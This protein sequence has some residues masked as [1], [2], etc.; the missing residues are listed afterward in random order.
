MFSN[1][2]PGSVVRLDKI[3]TKVSKLSNTVTEKNTLCNLD[4]KK[5]ARWIIINIL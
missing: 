1:N 3:T 2:T 5:T 4:F